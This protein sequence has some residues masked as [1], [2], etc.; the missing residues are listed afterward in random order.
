MSTSHQLSKSNGNAAG[1][2]AVPPSSDVGIR[3]IPIR[4]EQ[5]RRA[6]GFRGFSRI[7][8]S[9]GL[10]P[11]FR[12]KVMTNGEMNP[13]SLEQYRRLA[14]ALHH[15]QLERGIKRAMVAS[16][17]AGEGKTLTALNLALTLSASYHR[18]VLL[19]DA[20][21]RCPRVH[22]LLGVENASGLNDALTN[23]RQ[24]RASLLAVS[25]MLSVLP[26][27]RPNPDPM[28]AL[29]SERMTQVLNKA[30]ESYDWVIVDT[31][32][33]VML[34]DTSLLAAMIEVAVL[35]IR[36]GRTSCDLV[37]RAIAALGR[38]HVL[39]VVLNC[40]DEE[41]LSEYASSPYLGSSTGSVVR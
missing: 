21:L 16:A 9:C 29:T 36:A 12:G 6:S 31:A 24:S 23:T 17:V 22:E 34:P 35:V 2:V 32:P 39:G 30:A 38:D 40:V 3:G 13:V 19:I 37:D 27:G 25:P 28:G 33:V 5:P 1:A 14:A 4:K 26:A 8:K 7:V 20:D 15:T 10:N 41:N 11:A 18:R